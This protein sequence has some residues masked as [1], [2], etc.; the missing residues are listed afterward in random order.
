[1]D[2]EGKVLMESGK[3]M[4]IFGLAVGPDGE[5]VLVKGGD[6]KNVILTPSTGD[7]LQLPAYPP[8]DNML[9]I[10]D[11]YWISSNTLLGQSGVQA[12]DKNGK[13]LMTDNNV[14]ETRLYVYDL[15]AKQLTEVAMPAKLTQALVSVMEVSPDGHVHLALDAPPVGTDSDLGW[16]NIDA[17]K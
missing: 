3:E 8:G 12:L 5:H 15:T 16:F 13:P 4:G 10:G 14:A 6:G 7:K 11:W 17:P 9:C 1:M 2:R